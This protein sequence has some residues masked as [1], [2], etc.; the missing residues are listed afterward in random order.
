MQDRYID[1][2]QNMKIQYELSAIVYKLLL[3]LLLST[4][5]NGLPILFG[6]SFGNRDHMVV[7]QSPDDSWNITS[8]PR[9]ITPHLININ[10]TQ[11]HVIPRRKTEEELEDEILKRLHEIKV[12][13]IEIVQFVMKS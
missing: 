10:S 7:Y 3:S 12:R 2:E 13:K 9:S 11:N 8:I 5:V 6:T 1:F 4:N